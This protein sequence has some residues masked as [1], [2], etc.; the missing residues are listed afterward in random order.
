MKRWECSVCGY[1]HI[2]DGPPDVCPVCGADKSQFIL[3]EN[4]PSKAAKSD[5]PPA[6]ENADPNKS[7]QTKPA[8][9]GS[10]ST[11][12]MERK[13]WT[14]FFTL[15][16]KYH[17][18]PIAVHIPN[19]VLPLATLFLVLAVLFQSPSLATVAKYN[20]LF[21]FIFMPVVIATGIVDWRNRF[22]G[23]LTR[24]FMIKIVC[25]GIV[26]VL[27][28]LI[29]LWW[30]LQPYLY[31]SGTGRPFLV[32]VIYLINF[33]AAAIAGWNGGKLVFKRH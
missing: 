8:L 10:G 15:L 11:N 3:I 4:A 13:R 2:G 18:H 20:T 25:A 9:D 6:N 14:A 1:I 5:Q 28:G 32:I 21:V 12:T 30:L 22:K 24:V 26:T 16:T 33:C 19:G 27:S 23:R 29:C 31:Q 17:A 7:M